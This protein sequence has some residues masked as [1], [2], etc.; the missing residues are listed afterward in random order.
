MPVCDPFPCG[1]GGLASASP[2]TC[3]YKC[4]F[5][6]L[7]LGYSGGSAVTVNHREMEHPQTYGYFFALPVSGRKIIHANYKFLER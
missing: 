1:F 5:L 7:N 2:L 4:W 6:T 3:A